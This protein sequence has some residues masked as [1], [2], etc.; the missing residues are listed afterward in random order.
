MNQQPTMLKAAQSGPTPQLRFMAGELL[1]VSVATYIEA[2][3]AVA[4]LVERL[5]RQ[6]PA[7]YTDED[8]LVTRVSVYC[9]PA[10]WTAARRAKLRQGLAAIRARGLPVGR[11]RIAVRR[12][13][14]QDWAES[15]K[16]HFRPLAIGGALLIMPSWSRR[17][18]RP[19]EAVVVLDPG[20]SFGTGQHPTTAFCLA[21][22]AAGRQPGRALSFLDA[23]TGSGILAIAAAKLGYAPAH[24]FDNDAAAVRIAKE[25]ARLNGVAS[26]VR[27]RRADL[28]RLPRQSSRRYDLVCANLLAGLLVEQAPRI[29]AR[30]SPGGRLVLA[31]VLAEEF[32]QVTAVYE[33]AGLKL[34]ATAVRKQWQSGAFVRPRFAGE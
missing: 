7:L 4:A 9:R 22:L 19:G 18:P 5:F 3:E 16:R 13:H 10:A 31:G 6:S 33:K 8:S 1:S 29:L 26:L 30:L 27:I 2:E 34:A 15:W 20:L 11:G 28:T 14:P 17:R 32:P 12:L 23:G 24:A 25:N 21:Q